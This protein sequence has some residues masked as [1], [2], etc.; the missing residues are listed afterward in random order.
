M[1]GLK[2][3]PFQKEVGLV[4]PG[5]N[6]PWPPP[7]DD[8]RVLSASLAEAPPRGHPATGWLASPRFSPA[9][10]LGLC[11]STCRDIVRIPR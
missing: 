11:S 3:F 1:E 9:S 5:A 7:L 8:P 2:L 10:R 6:D 4:D